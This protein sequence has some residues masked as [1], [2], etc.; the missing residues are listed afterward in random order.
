MVADSDGETALRERDR[1]S[2]EGSYDL[3][4]FAALRAFEAIGTCGGIRNAAEALLTDYATVSRHMRALEAWFGVP[5]WDRTRGGGGQFTPAGREYYRRVASALA[6]IALA[7]SELTRREDISKLTL[8]C[9][10][11]IAS[12]WLAGRLG[13]FAQTHPEVDITLVP[14]EDTPDFSQHHADARLYYEADTQIAPREE[15][16]VR[17]L[18]IARPPTLAVASPELLDLMGAPQ[19]PE[20]LPKMPLLHEGPNDGEWRRWLAHYGVQPASLPGVHFQHGHL[21]LAAAREGSGVALANELLVRG[22]LRTGELV[23]L[24][25]WTPVNLGSYVFEARRDRWRNS[26]I[27]SFRAWLEKSIFEP[28]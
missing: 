7:T 2:S 5:L 25:D 1:F 3:P 6:E 10:P 17:R 15:G 21:T 9:Y 8:W 24:G 14:T 27:A 18:R 13:D 19:R 4:P 11:G 16:F 22:Y 12:E 26:I 28:V 23:Q 20:D